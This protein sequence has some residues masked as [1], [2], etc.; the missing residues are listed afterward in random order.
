M[1]H[2]SHVRFLLRVVDNILSSEPFGLGA[3]RSQKGREGDFSDVG[4]GVI[5]MRDGWTGSGSFS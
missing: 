5:V 2:V 3:L 4:A 1:L